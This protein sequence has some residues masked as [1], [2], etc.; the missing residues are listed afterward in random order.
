MNVC[1]GHWSSLQ[2]LCWLKQRVKIAE[3]DLLSHKILFVKSKQNILHLHCIWG[4]EYDLHLWVSLYCDQL[5]SLRCHFKYCLQLQERLKEGNVSIQVQKSTVI[6]GQSLFWGRKAKSCVFIH[7]HP[8]VWLPPKISASHVH[9]RHWFWF[10][11]CFKGNCENIVWL[12]LCK[13]FT[14][15]FSNI[16]TVIKVELNIFIV[17]NL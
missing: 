1:A 8:N 17:E 6:E 5:Y 2:A 13:V 9:I 11:F 4:T 10:N 15:S 16:N 14:T 7:T 12:Q 3:M